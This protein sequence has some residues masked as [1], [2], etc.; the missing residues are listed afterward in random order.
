MSITKTFR[1]TASS[2]ILISIFLGIALAH[3]T[4]ENNYKTNN[5]LLT[6]ISETTHIENGYKAHIILNPDTIA[7]YAQ[8][9]GYKLNLAIA[10]TGIGGSH[11]ENNYKLDLVPEK[12]PPEILN[13][14]VTNVQP[15]KSIVGQGFTLNITITIL[16][17]DLATEEFFLTIY[18]N[19]TAI[20][21]ETITLAGRN[22]ITYTLTWNTTGYAK[23]NYNIS[24]YAWPLPTETN[25][26]DNTL[27]NGTVRISIPGDVDPCDGYVG[28]DDI[29]AIASH[30]AQEPNHPK[31]NPIYDLN[32]DLY[33]G[34]DDIFTAAQHFA[35]EDP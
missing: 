4:T 5:N 18:A 35:E 14:Q 8:E 6:D 7:I 21:T 31:W 30:F 9:N 10:P 27:T 2:L 26:A 29:Y 13:L 24:A 16:N 23:G 12:S 17:P 20:K 34:I 22:T 11:K 19:T 32:N 15:S 3:A 25:T 28:I 33:V 1:R